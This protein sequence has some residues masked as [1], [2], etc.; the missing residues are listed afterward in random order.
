MPEDALDL[1][2]YYNS[3]GETNGNGE[4][5][6]KELTSIS[7]ILFE[8]LADNLPKRN[9]DIRVGDGENK[10]T[11]TYPIP[12]S[13]EDA[14][15]YYNST[16]EELKA[17]GCR[18]ATYD[19]DNNVRTLISDKRD[20]GVDPNDYADQVKDL[21]ETALTTDK[22]KKVSEAKKIK[23]AKTETGMSIDEMIAYAKAAKE[24]GVEIEK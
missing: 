17:A 1:K 11:I 12:Q 8:G 10:F 5:T 24:Q 21:L 23:E 20:A 9:R 13:E 22:A 19:A 16:E 3:N 2:D 15:D 18:Q 14:K 6:K 7:I 4:E